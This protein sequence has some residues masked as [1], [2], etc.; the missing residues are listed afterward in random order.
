MSWMTHTC[1]AAAAMVL[2]SAAIA[3]SG[4]VAGSSLDI[5][6]EAPKIDISFWLKGDKVVE[7]EEGKVYVIEF[8]ATWCGECKAT[9]PHI[10]KLQQSY[11]DY[12][13]RF[14]GISDEN[15]M[16]VT[17]FIQQEEWDQKTR[18]TIATDPDRSVYRDY[19]TAAGERGIPTAFIVGRGGY[20]EWIGDPMMIERPLELITRDQWDREA[21]RGERILVRR[22]Q[23]AGSPSEAVEVLDKLIAQSNDPALYQLQKAHL[24][25]TELNQPQE[26][27]RLLEKGVKAFWDDSDVLNKIAGS[28]ADGQ[29]PNP[30]LALGLRIA[31]RACDLTAYKSGQVLDTLARVHYRRG[32]LRKAVEIQKLA[33]EHAEA[34]VEAEIQGR[35]K[36]YLKEASKR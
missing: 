36:E 21:A 4:A 13:V 2:A 3:Q 19:M 28:L 16:T 12:G 22:L 24:L 26:G 35:L 15:L 18:Y 34:D 6:D 10:S 9:M 25:L 32:E 29:F 5:G 8:W 33:V 23:A 20:I 7:F 27:Y 14:L 11:K 17:D 1:G 31:E 30:D